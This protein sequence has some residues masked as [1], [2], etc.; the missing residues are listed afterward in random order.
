MRP[1]I[2]YPHMSEPLD[3]AP[4]LR[5][6]HLQL[7]SGLPCDD[8]RGGPVAEGLTALGYSKDRRPWL[9]RYERLND[10][11]LCWVAIGFTGERATPVRVNV[12][13]DDMA[14]LIVSHML[15]PR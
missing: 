4:I 9:L 11:S 5:D 13:R 6:L 3:G 1:P 8:G 12:L 14:S 7:C 15:T 10:G 2:C